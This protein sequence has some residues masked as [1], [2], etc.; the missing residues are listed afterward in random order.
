MEQPL[1]RNSIVDELAI[2]DNAALARIVG[3]DDIDLL[4][5]V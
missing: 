3:R 4:A 5:A 1:P 2:G